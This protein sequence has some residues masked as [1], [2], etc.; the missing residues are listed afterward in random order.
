MNEIHSNWAHCT[1]FNVMK[2]SVDRQSSLTLLNA[3]HKKNHKQYTISRH[4]IAP[5]PPSPPLVP[6][7][8]P[9]FPLVL[10]L[11]RQTSQHFKSEGHEPGHRTHRKHHPGPVIH[12]VVP[13]RKPHANIARLKLHTRDEQSNG[14]GTYEV[15]GRN[16]VRTG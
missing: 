14:T 9:S 2:Y 11:P 7:H 6:P 10:V 3:E 4:G 12:F 8:S 13:A 15:R 5:L 16:V 1:Y